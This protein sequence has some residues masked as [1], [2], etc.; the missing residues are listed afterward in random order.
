MLGMLCH[1]YITGSQ[2]VFISSSKRITERELWSL[3]NQMYKSGKPWRPL[4]PFGKMVLGPLLPRKF[5]KRKRGN[6]YSDDFR[7]HVVR[8]VLGRQRQSH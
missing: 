1:R 3:R 2:Y 7:E 4:L 5:R 6:D 8:K